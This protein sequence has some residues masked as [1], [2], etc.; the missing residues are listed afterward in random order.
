MKAREKAIF[1]Y[2]S[3]HREEMIA[4]LV[5]LVG[6]ES[7]TADKA[8]V[9]RCGAVLAELYQRRLGVT[10]R[11][12]PQ[13]E[14]GDNLVTELGSGD[15]KLLIVGHFDTVHPIGAVPIRR[16]GEILYGPGVTDMK[17]GDVAVIWALRALKELGIP[18]DKRVVVAN[19]S[20]EETGSHHS[21]ELLLEL[22]K[23][24][25]ACIIA[26]PAAGTEG[27]IKTSRKGGG[28]I[29]IRCYGKASHAGS[30][31]QGGVNANVE[32]A[33]QIIFA[34]GLSDYGPGGS[35]F[36]PN[37]ISGGTVEN[38]TSDHAEAVV[39]W[40]VCVPE[41][42]DRAR[43]IFA[44]RKA[45]LPG[46]RVEFELRLGHPPM[47]ET[48]GGR[49]LFALLQAC[50]ADLDMAVK[51]APTV[52]GCSDGNDISAAGVPTIDGMGVV[53]NFMHSPKEQMFL[54]DFVPRTALMAS[55]IARV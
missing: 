46:A 7:P 27:L 34:Y 35:T 28:A 13:A 51:A 9:D 47:P 44:A 8:A 52:G 49:K 14:A 20:D 38:V 15:K 40:R 37:V 39:D 6:A 10:S 29:T 11:V 26:E 30:D 45:V 22:A 17:G 54:K 12:V 31:P 2:L 19:N 55:F 1:D 5:E 43:A 42:V 18:L 50:G 41:E 25:D 53:G 33:H 23:D 32:L 3:A 36:G 4:D 48:E 16:E 24:A 21:K